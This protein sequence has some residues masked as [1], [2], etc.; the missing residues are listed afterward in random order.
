MIVTV[1]H[2][3]VVC[4]TKILRN[5]IYPLNTKTTPFWE[6]WK[7]SINQ[8]LVSKNKTLIHVLFP[9]KSVLIRSFIQFNAF[10]VITPEHCL[11]VIIKKSNILRPMGILWSSDKIWLMFDVLNVK[12]MINHFISFWYDYSEW[13]FY[14]YKKNLLKYYKVYYYKKLYVHYSQPVLYSIINRE[15]E[16]KCKKKE[17][18][19]F[20]SHF[21][22][23]C[24]KHFYTIV[25]LYNKVLITKNIVF[26]SLFS[27]FQ[28]VFFWISRK[29][30]RFSKN[31]LFQKYHLVVKRD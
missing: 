11:G 6:K 9:S 17:M 19:I 21:Q 13:S 29:L 25:Y 4:S 14:L 27:K 26:E 3:C 28:V 20:F 15:E 8:V 30:L 1:W 23:F 22:I 16:K 18:S 12:E 31:D 10:H 2:Y 24:T 7:I 5:T